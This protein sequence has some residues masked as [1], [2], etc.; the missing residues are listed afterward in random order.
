MII[1]ALLAAPMING[2]TV[3]MRPVLRFQ[4][5]IILLAVLPLLEPDKQLVEPVIIARA[6]FRPLAVPMLSGQTVPMR[7]VSMLRMDTILLEEPLQLERGR[8]NVQ[9]AH[10]VLA[11]LSLALAPPVIIV[12]PAVPALLKLLAPREQL[13]P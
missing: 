9:P 7:F 6:A 13:T 2:L 5:V 10:T 4:P 1:A 11:V 8:L 12:Q 3:A